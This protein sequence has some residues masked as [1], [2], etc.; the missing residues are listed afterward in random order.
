MNDTP[1]FIARKQYEINNSKTVKERFAI[2]EGMMSFVR[3]MTIKRIKKRLG[4]DIS[5]AQL[6]YEIIKE[7][8]GGELSSEQLS[9]IQV[10]LH[11]K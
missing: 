1:A 5:D 4:D 8:Y 9:E 7:Y 11:S 10:R 6:K 2:F 3:L